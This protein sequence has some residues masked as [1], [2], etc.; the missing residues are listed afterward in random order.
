FINKSQVDFSSFSLCTT[1]ESYIKIKDTIEFYGDDYYLLLSNGDIF[2][3]TYPPNRNHSNA[4][5]V[6]SND[7]T[8]HYNRI[9]NYLKKCDVAVIDIFSKE[10]EKYFSLKELRT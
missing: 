9:F 7:S 4:F 2:H 10:D 3:I 8:K 6:I 5:S 1:L